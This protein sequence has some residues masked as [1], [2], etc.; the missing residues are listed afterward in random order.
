LGGSEKQQ[1]V[2]LRGKGTIHWEGLHI[3]Y[4][5]Q[6]F[7]VVPSTDPTD[8]TQELADLLRHLES[9]NPFTR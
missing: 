6:E 3:R 8:P 2:V 7:K 1:R 5:P 4:D 9:R